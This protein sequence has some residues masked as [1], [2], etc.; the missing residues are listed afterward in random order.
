MRIAI[1]ILLSLLSTSN[2]WSQ[3][4]EK[5]R[6]AG[7]VVD[8]LRPQNFYNL[9]VINRTK[10]K[11]VFGL[12]N[13]GY[14]VYAEQGDSIT[15]SIKGYEKVDYIV[16]ADSN[17]QAKNTWYID[18]LPQQVVEVV[19][20]PLKTLSE[21]QAERE[22]L[23]MQETRMVTGIDVL[24][25]PI[26]ALYQVFSKKEKSKRAV[27][28]YKYA[29]EQK[30]VLQDLLRLYVAYDIFDLN[31]KEFDSFIAFLNINEDFLKTAS[32]LELVTFIK[33]KFEHFK[34]L[35]KL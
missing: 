29:D 4:C 19:I 6:L 20:K 30:A 34:M 31:E 9:M 28:K 26:T 8:S 23:A 11:G 2:S 1:I 18:M 15:F 22:G 3:D 35:N 16:V 17:C 24:Q 14:N 32:E 25:S 13:G 21:I 10:G 5:V 27:A 33:D 7:R 12:P